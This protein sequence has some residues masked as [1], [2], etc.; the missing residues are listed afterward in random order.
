MTHEEWAE[1]ERLRVQ[2]A[3]VAYE[4]AVVEG[5]TAPAPPAGGDPLIAWLDAAPVTSSPAVA[6][7]VTAA[8]RAVLD[9]HKPHTVPVDHEDLD[10][11]T[12]CDSCYSEWPCD[13]R[14]EVAEALGVTS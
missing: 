2:A 1:A 6:L 13:T 4:H 3:T 14:T 12:F 7:R 9:I 11:H 10:E 5:E 8:L